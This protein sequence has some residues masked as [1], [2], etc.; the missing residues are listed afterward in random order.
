MVL[1][2]RLKEF[3][4]DNIVRYGVSVPVAGVR[5]GGSR[6][7]RDIALIMGASLHLGKAKPQASTPPADA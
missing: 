5:D 1:S 7:I 6:E 3:P 4:E 2:S